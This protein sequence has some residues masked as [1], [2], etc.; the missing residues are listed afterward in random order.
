MG[1]SLGRK[2]IQGVKEPKTHLMRN[3]MCD[4]TDICMQT[5]ART[6]AVCHMMLLTPRIIII[7]RFSH[8]G[9]TGPSQLPRFVYATAMVWIKKWVPINYTPFTRSSLLDKLANH[10]HS[11]PTSTWLDDLTMSL[12]FLRLK[13]L[14]TPA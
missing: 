12:Q 5:E 9:E 8:L 6:N 7:G 3:A 14:V 10:V 13:Q 1:R 11:R 4:A 2:R